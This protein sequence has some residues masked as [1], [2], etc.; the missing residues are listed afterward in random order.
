MEKIEENFSR[1]IYPEPCEN[2]I[3]DGIYLVTAHEITEDSTRP[4]LTVYRI[5]VKKIDDDKKLALCFYI[6][7][8]FEE[9]I[10]LVDSNELKLYQIS[11][12][13]L[14]IPPQAIHFSL[15]N[16][17]DFAENGLAQSEA[18]QSLSN[19]QFL[20]KI[21]STK[22]QYEKQL[23][24]NGVAKVNVMLFDMSK[25]ENVN[26][27]KEILGNICSKLRPPQLEQNQSTVVHVTHVSDI[28]EI[29]CRHHNS[30]EMHHIK[31][32]INRLTQNGINEA[33]R[34]DAGDL[35]DVTSK[36]LRLVYDSTDKRWCRA[37][38]LP[39]QMPRRNMARC[40]FVDYGHIKFVE[41]EHMYK[42]ERLSTALSKYPP[43]SIVVRLNGF[44]PND[45]TTNIIRRL[46]ELL[47]CQK[48][49]LIK[50]IDQSDI[51]AVDIW[52]HVGSLLC[53]IND[54]IRMEM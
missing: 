36:A 1:G 50:S 29:H 27:N 52:K 23:M 24:A 34:L 8:G 2:V 7:D 39:S 14:K 12:E 47:C 5:K 48:T 18:A 26:M 46:R 32:L 51:I 9:W 35:N 38:V 11:R 21:K 45:Y 37:M 3:V 49:V 43:Q 15:F 6:D 54:A 30:K 16:L 20:A 53:K 31:Q 13:L 44:Q 33:Y 28:G 25:E 4:T 17:E 22:E 41:H 42:L 40:Q 19:R 10:S